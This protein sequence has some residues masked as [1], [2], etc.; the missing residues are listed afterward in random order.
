MDRLWLDYRRA[1]PGRRR[2]GRL[3]LAA[4]VLAAVLTWGDYLAVSAE[5]D[6]A[7]AQAETQ[8]RAA[9]RARAA[10][11]GAPGPE[12]LRTAAPSAARWEGLFS[13]L[14]A[15][16]DD[17]VTLLSLHPGEK[18]IQIGGEAKDFG[19]SADYFQ[20]LQSAPALANVRMT[21]S[22]VVTE[23]PQ[24]PVRFMLVA[25]WRSAR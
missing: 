17:S 9:E 23:N 5:R 4:G 12:A 14:E 15:A 1:D 8:R 19:A 22:E 10:P 3:L 13:S 18:E 20:R 6:D 24:H 21:Q 11:R 2:L 7:Q 16:A 25:E